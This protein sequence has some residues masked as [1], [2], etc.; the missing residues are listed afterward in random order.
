MASRPVNQRL[1]KLV[2]QQITE[3]LGATKPAVRSHIH[4]IVQTL[5]TERA[6]ALLRDAQELEQPSDQ[7]LADGQRRMPGGVFFRLVGDQTSPD[8]QKQIWPFKPR[9][10]APQQT[11]QALTG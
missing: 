5:G 7:R 9:A 11:E 6:L 8:E 3:A 2:T 10:K 1:G 4:W